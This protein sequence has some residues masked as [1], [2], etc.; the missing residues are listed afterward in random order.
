MHNAM[1]WIKEIFGLN[2]LSQS[3]N[4]IRYFRLN[5]TKQLNRSIIDSW[6]VELL[7]QNTISIFGI[8]D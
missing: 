8:M 3:F 7:P 4:Q 1:E 2:I 5:D 6:S